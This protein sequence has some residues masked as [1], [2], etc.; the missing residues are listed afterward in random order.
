[1]SFTNSRPVP[2][3][4]TSRIMRAVSPPTSGSE[5][6]STAPT[7]MTPSV[8]AMGAANGSSLVW[9]PATETASSTA[10]TPAPKRSLA[11]VMA[12]PPAR[13]PL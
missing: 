5:A 11:N 3:S 10:P 13:F 12:P 7:R 6:N 9:A 2:G 8:A 1:M 4:S